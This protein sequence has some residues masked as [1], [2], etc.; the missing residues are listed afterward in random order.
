[1]ENLPGK[2]CDVSEQSGYHYHWH[3]GQDGDEDWYS[4]R[5]ADESVWEQSLHAIGEG[6]SVEMYP[7]PE[8][9]DV[10]LDT[11]DSREEALWSVKELMEEYPDG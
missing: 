4:I 6:W 11:F 8:G 9:D 3:H 10:M 7:N 5:A 1:M 2:W